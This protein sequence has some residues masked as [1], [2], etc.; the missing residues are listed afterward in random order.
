MLTQQQIQE[1]ARNRGDIVST[2][3]VVDTTNRVN[4][5]QSAWST[6]T[7][8]NGFIG[9]VINT[10]K[11]IV[12]AM[13]KS[14]QYLGQDIGRAILGGDKFVSRIVGQYQENAKKL[15]DLAEKQTDPILKQKYGM[16]AAGMLDDAE[17]V[18]LDLKGRTSKQIIGD[19][20]GVALDVGTTLTGLGAAKATIKTPGIIKGAVQGAKTGALAGAAYGGSY[21]VVGGLQENKDLSGVIESGISGA[22]VG[23]LTGGALGAVAGGVSGG[24]LGHSE[25]ATKKEEIFGKS[26]VMP[27]ATDKVKKQALK[28]GRITEQGLLKGSSIVPSK[29]DE[30]VYEAVK[31]VISSKK[32]VVQNLDSI[33]SKV[34][35]INSGVGAYVETYKKPFN[36]NQLRTQLNAGKGDLNLVFASDKTAQKTYEAVV[37]EFMKHVAK[38]DT[39]GLF[40]ARQGFDKVPAIK[41]LLDSRALGENTKKEIVLTVRDMANKYIANLL[42][43][44]NQ[45]KTALLQETRMLNAIDNIASSNS[46]TVG[47]SKLIELMNKYPILKWVASGLAGAGGVGVGSVILNSTD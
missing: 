11:N 37:N 3:P 21:G 24:I 9:N 43:K 46:S 23:G 47:K 22:T 26:F 28:E 12:N 15:T 30:N 13:T 6:P 19:V 45:Y 36:T 16:M 1:I 39:K 18:G 31:D 7:K 25:K 4:E 42:P 34:E 44:G 8:D 38:K 27:K 14:E 20:L 33:S 17:K 40:L 32:S 2:Q 35:E 41:K 29:R 10:G 5:L